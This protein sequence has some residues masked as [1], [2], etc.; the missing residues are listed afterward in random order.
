MLAFPFA[1]LAASRAEFTRFSF[2]M[3]PVCSVCCRTARSRTSD[4]DVSADMMAVSISLAI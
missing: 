3:K 4:T 1:V 2:L